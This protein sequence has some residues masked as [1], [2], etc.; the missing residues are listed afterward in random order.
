MDWGLIRNAVRIAITAALDLPTSAV[1]WAGT[2]ESGYF[3]ASPQV[4]LRLRFP[5]AIGTDYTTFEYDH[6]TGKTYTVTNGQRRFTVSVSI[7]SE[8]QSENFEAVGH[9]AARFRSRLR[10]PEILAILQAAGV[11]LITIESTQDTD[12]TVNSRQMS[13][14]LTDVVFAAAEYDKEETSPTTDY[15][16][17]VETESEIM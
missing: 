5:T 12:T 2:A 16:E 14:S 7:E 11:A 1:Q 15:I 6:I 10:R 13:V 4:D 8:S 9:F 3:R 17:T